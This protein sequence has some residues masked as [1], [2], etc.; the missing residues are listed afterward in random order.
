LRVNVDERKAHRNFK[1]R[2]ILCNRSHRE[3]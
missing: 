3:Q 2:D 1:L